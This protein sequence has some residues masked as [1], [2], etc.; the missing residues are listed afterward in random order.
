VVLCEHLAWYARVEADPSQEFYVV[1]AGGKA[2]GTIGL[3]NIDVHHHRAEYGRFLIAP[4]YR[5]RGYGE[6]A[7][8]ALLDRAFGKMELHRVWGD[9][10]AFND[11]ALRLDRK[12]GFQQEGVF[13]QHVLKGKLWLDV[14][15]M[16]ILEE[17]WKIGAP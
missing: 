10:F 16:G 2:V 15:R 3:S 4:E 5:R 6:A 11:P 13:R 9:V 12:L 8:R 7:M 1:E 14:V 17:E